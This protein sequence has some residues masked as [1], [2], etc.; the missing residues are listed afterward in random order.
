[1]TDILTTPLPWGRVLLIYPPYIH[2]ATCNGVVSDPAPFLPFGPLYAGQ[3]LER[4]GRAEVGYFDCQLHGLPGWSDLQNYDTFGIS[5]MGAQNVAVAHRVFNKLV[6]EGIARDRVYLGGQGVEWLDPEEFRTVFPGAWQAPRVVLSSLSGYMDTNVEP[7]F[8]K[9]TQDDLHTYLSAELT[10]PMSQGCMF[11]C[12]FCAAQIRRRET[13]YNTFAAA[14]AYLAR[15][16]E[17]GLKALHFY[18][19]SLDFFQGALSGQDIRPLI[20]RLEHLIDLQERFGI[21]LV[22]R[23]L[24]RA[25]S[26]NAAMRSQELCDLVTRAGFVRFGFGADGAASIELLN[27]MHRGTTAL[28]SD[29]LQA[30]SHCEQHRFIPEMLY[31][32]GVP[33]DTESTLQATRDLLVGLLREFPHSQYRGFPAKNEIPGNRNWA[34][35]SWKRSGAYELLFREPRYFLNLGFE[36]LANNISHPDRTR[37]KLVNRYATEMSFIAH[38]LNRVQ[39]YLTVPLMVEDGSELLD[40]ESFEWFVAITRRYLG[41]AH[42]RITL[43]DFPVLRE[44]LNRFIPKDR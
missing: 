34:C 22:L 28:K 7:Q 41:N 36:T 24:T 6:A 30:F 44:H 23:A 32:F 27:S 9:F 19:T 12:S 42:E 38:E 11:G 25:D 21:R 3:L 2:Y 35:D 26:Y 33:E 14:G 10:L 15:A 43:E 1:M 8:R 4:M 18:C 39:S 5:V 40:E 31:V 13:F 16:A 37:R 17:L 29:L 20:E